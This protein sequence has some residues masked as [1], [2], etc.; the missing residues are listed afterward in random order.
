MMAE[1]ELVTFAYTI[2]SKRFLRIFV[3]TRTGDRA[4]EADTVIMGNVK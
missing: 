1:N 3:A 2:F 4:A